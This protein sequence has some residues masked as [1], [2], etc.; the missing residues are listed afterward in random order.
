MATPGRDDETGKFISPLNDLAL[1]MVVGEI[2]RFA[3]PADP[4][5]VTQ[6]R[7][8][9]ARAP[10][11]YPDAP[12]AYATTKRLKQSW[13]AI[14]ELAS[15]PN[16]DYLHTLSQRRR[17]SPRLFSKQEAA[18]AVSAI[19]ESLGRSDYLRPDEYDAA[20]VRIVEAD[21][22][23]WR[24]GV[25]LVAYFPSATQID[26]QWGW[27]VIQEEAG[28]GPRPAPGSI[29]GV[30]TLE[31]VRMFVDELDALPIRSTIQRYA[32]LKDFSL[33]LLDKAKVE[34]AIDQ[35]REERSQAG[36]SLPERALTLPELEALNLEPLDEPPVPARKG[37]WTLDECEDALLRAARELHAK[38]KPQALKQRTYRL[39][40]KGR[41]DMP[42]ASTITDVARKHGTTFSK[43][44]DEAVKRAFGGGPA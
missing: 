26:F 42:T 17:L 40:A 36:Q 29:A 43:L 28:L 27:D 10:A 13:P 22:R 20:Q 35:L 6:V 33:A 14:L 44:R 38:R 32:A 37:A 7:Y 9:A 25:G 16:R 4:E 12:T 1:V 18:D 23:A 24:H 8:N 2:A 39:H 30:E 19:A 5:R 3:S 41:R 15:D 34:A 31:A 21:E 11:G